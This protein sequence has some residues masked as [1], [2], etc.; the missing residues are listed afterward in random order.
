[1][2]KTRPPYPLEFRQHLVDLVLAGRSH[3]DLA[4]EFEPSA[5][6]VIDYC[7]M[8][9]KPCMNLPI[10]VFCLQAEVRHKIEGKTGRTRANSYAGSG[11]RC[12]WDSTERRCQS[13]GGRSDDSL[14]VVPKVARGPRLIK[15]KAD[16][17]ANATIEQRATRTLNRFDY[18][19]SASIRLAKRSLDLYSRCRSNTESVRGFLPSRPCLQNS[20]K[21]IG[22][23]LPKTREGVSGTRSRACSQLAQRGAAGNQKKVAEETAT[24]VLIDEACFQFLPVRKRTLAPRGETP[25]LHA[26]DCRAKFSVIG[27]I[28][29]SRT[30]HRP[31]FIFSVLSEG[32]NFDSV[33]VTTFLRKLRRRIPGP[34]HIIWDGAN[35]HRGPAVKQFLSRTKGISAHRFPPYAPDTKPTEGC[36]GHSKY[37]QLPNLVAQ[38]SAELAN[39]AETSLYEIANRLALLNSF[40]KHAWNH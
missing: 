21:E 32:D 24:L 33:R 12:R 29:I 35:I 10:G 17:W 20:D 26:W 40:I 4:K 25:K 6:T 39:A 37:H 28:T 15:S 8:I 7:H 22:L 1:M 30:K 19:W 27:A 31:N 36:W 3:E 13:V 9:T 18:Q 34:S 38:N 23:F 16:S 5:V 11:S 2:P 14:Q